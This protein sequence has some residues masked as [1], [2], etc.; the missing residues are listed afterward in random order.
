M[1]KVCFKIGSFFRSRN[2]CFIQKRHPY[3]GTLNSETSGDSNILFP[4]RG[5]ILAFFC[6]VLQGP[7]VQ[8]DSLDPKLCWETLPLEATQC[9]GVVLKTI[10]DH[11]CYG[12]SHTSPAV[13]GLNALQ[14]H[15]ETAL[16][17]KYGKM[18]T[19]ANQTAGAVGESHWPFA[20]RH[21]QTS[22]VDTD[23]QAL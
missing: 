22:S 21:R 20:C 17:T 11:S 4:H 2:V 18:Q 5:D 3:T 9:L 13:L 1:L 8:S 23:K 14:Q 6:L 16:Q 19:V 12:R 10:T 7:S 15:L